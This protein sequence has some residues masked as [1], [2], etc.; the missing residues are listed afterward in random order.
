[1]NPWDTAFRHTPADLADHLA[2]HRPHLAH[3]RL[4]FLSSGWDNDLYRV[5]QTGLL[6]RVPRRSLSLALLETEARVLPQLAPHLPVPLPLPVDLL[7]ATNPLP[8]MALVRFLPGTTA[9]RAPF[10]TVNTPT[11]AQQ[12]GRALAQLHRAPLPAGLP[13]DTLQRVDLIG[14][15]QRL[16]S[17]RER[18]RL[19]RALQHGGLPFG[20]GPLL[21]HLTRLARVPHDTFRPRAVVHGDLYARHVLI[22][23]DGELAGLIDWGDVH[24]GSPVLDLMAAWL[25]F[26]QDVRQHFIQAAGT[27]SP[28]AW[29]AARSRAGLHACRTLVFSH[30]I[31]DHALF[32]ASVRG[33]RHVCENSD[34]KSD[35]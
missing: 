8:P 3:H 21:D 2:T 34:L 23:S 22:G 28:E 5:G 11:I 1:M 24:R 12:L 9:C 26:S 32:A 16:R 10:H 20:P 15:L 29:R 31:D 30:S 18:P 14:R 27:H 33:L 4:G 6:L 7:P 19:A 17:D 35:P 25:L 13:E